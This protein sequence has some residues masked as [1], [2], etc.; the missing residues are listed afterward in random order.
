MIIT[1]KD[2]LVSNG[3]PLNESIIQQLIKSRNIDDIQTYLNP[4]TPVS[5]NIADFGY[6]QEIKRSL[7]I[8][9]DV[10]HKNGTVVVYTD[11]DADGITG[12]TILWETLHLLGF[13]A[14]PYVPHR[15]HEGY[16]FSVK[17]IDAVREKYNPSLIISVDHGIAAAEKVTYAKS[18]NIPIIITD[19]HL[20]PE[21][22]PTNDD[23]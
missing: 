18:L 6:E 13:K 11:Y 22:I 7:E 5:M 1:Y 20:K 9:T 21:H 15:K 23:R 17:G 19:H 10:K 4:P 2:V 12:G 14:M 16:G 8:L 3:L